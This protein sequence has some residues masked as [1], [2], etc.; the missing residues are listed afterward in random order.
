[1]ELGID[2]FAITHLSA[3]FQSLD[4]LLEYYIEY[5]TM[6]LRCVT[7]VFASMKLYRGVQ[8]VQMIVH[9]AFGAVDAQLASCML[10]Q[11]LKHV[12]KQQLVSTRKFH[13]AA[14]VLLSLFI[15]ID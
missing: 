6:E 4:I 13:T 14:I 11:I 9:V 1:M 8:A 15:L 2:D 3:M 10:F 7:Y 5:V 12:F